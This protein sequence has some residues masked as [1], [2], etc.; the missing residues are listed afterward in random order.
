M[1]CF[2][3]S[4]LTFGGDGYRARDIYHRK[5]RLSSHLTVK[6]SA[7]FSLGWFWKTLLLRRT[8]FSRNSWFVEAASK[9]GEKSCAWP[10]SCLE[11]ASLTSLG[12]FEV[13]VEIP[14]SLGAKGHFNEAIQWK[15]RSTSSGR[16]CG[17]SEKIVCSLLF[18]L[19]YTATCY[20]LIA[21]P[22]KC[23][24]RAFLSRPLNP[25]RLF[26]VSCHELC[27]RCQYEFSTILN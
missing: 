12:D 1:Q 13:S 10:L 24:T 27:T 11:E 6:L 9:F 21:I 25:H 26:F 5:M 3:N 7:H 4:S 20:Q 8:M 2:N 22:S 19:D 23:C 16:N 18:S 15:A 17:I 14:L